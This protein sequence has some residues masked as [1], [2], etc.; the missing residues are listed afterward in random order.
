MYLKNVSRKVI[1]HSNIL[2]PVAYRGVFERGL[3][4]EIER[5]TPPQSNMLSEN[6]FQVVAKEKNPCF[7]SVSDF[8]F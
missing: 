8:L 6:F 4:F 3:V 7:E 1:L 5:A 2:F